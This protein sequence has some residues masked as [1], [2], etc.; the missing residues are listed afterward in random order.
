M[1]VTT[2]CAVGAAVGV[3]CPSVASAAVLGLGSHFVLDAL[4][5][6]G[7]DPACP[8]VRDRVAVVDGAAGLLVLGLLSF[9]AVRLRSPLTRRMLV[10]AVAASMPDW[11]KPYARFIGGE[12]WP[13]PVNRLHR[14]IQPESPSRLRREVVLGALSLLSV[15][16]WAGIAVSRRRS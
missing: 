7:S 8:E 12:L 16:T 1:L 5:H 3:V 2:H 9:S 4:P 11:D 6:W 13:D 14:S 10:S 15:A